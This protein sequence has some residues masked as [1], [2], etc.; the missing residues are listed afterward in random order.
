MKRFFSGS[1]SLF[2]LH[3]LSFFVSFIIG[4]FF[5][6]LMAPPPQV[7]MKFPTPYNA[8]K[9]VYRDKNDTCYVYKAEKNDCPADKT[10]IKPHP[11]F[12]DFK[13]KKVAK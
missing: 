6:Y 7:V 5:V 2:P 8:G 10:K 13:N 9:V 12:E 3:P 4:L 1:F 11:V